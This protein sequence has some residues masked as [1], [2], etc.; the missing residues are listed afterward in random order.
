MKKNVTISKISS[1]IILI[2]FL[3]INT[4][5]YGTNDKY[6]TTLDTSVKAQRDSEIVVEIGID[7]ISIESGEK[8]IGAYVGRIKYDKDVLEYKTTNESTNWEAPIFQNGLIIGNTKLGQVEKTKQSIGSVTFTVKENAPLGNTT[9]KVENFSA[10]TGV[11]DISSTDNESIE[12][13]IVANSGNG[14]NTGSDKP[15]TGDSNKDDNNQ[16]NETVNNSGSQDKKDNQNNQDKKSGILPK[17][18]ANN[19]VLYIALALCII[20]SVIGVVLI[21]NKPKKE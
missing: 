14:E 11:T 9:I 1:G 17:L 4:N 12:V 15:S 3:L 13:N 6:S 20:S 10:S 18:G 19:T 7:N 2:V 16:N 8:G 5:V 21:Q